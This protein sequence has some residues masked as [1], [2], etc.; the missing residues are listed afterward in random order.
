MLLVITDANILIDLYELDLLE[1]FFQLPFDVHTS[2]FIL[3]ELDEDCALVVKRVVKVLDVNS[4]QKIQLDA[5]QWNSGFSFP[6]KSILFLAKINSMM[7]LS[8]EKKMMTWCKSNKLVGHGILYVF[9]SFVDN[10]LLSAE[11]TADKLSKLIEFN[12]WL[13]MDA[14]LSLIETWRAES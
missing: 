4:T 1:L 8:G 7:V 10:G 12:H 6:D 13:P 14:C 2:S 11:D 9:Q 3:D 5:M